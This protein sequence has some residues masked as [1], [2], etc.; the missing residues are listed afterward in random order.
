MVCTTLVTA[1]QPAHAAA[2]VSALRVSALLAVAIGPDDLA[3]NMSHRLGPLV[4]Q[5]LLGST[6][7]RF[8]ARILPGTLLVHLFTAVNLQTL[9]RYTLR[10]SFEG[11]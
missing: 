1:S 4:R 10:S 5:S 6:S 11:L 9:P 8:V 2:S 7:F 3:F